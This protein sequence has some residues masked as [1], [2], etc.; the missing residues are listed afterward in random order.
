MRI[1][2]KLF[3]YFGILLLICFGVATL[4]T[5]TVVRM[6]LDKIVYANVAKMNQTIADSLDGS[7][8]SALTTDL[9][10][11]RDMTG[12]DV[13]VYEGDTL[14]YSSFSGTAPDLSLAS[15]VSEEYEV[16]VLHSGD[17]LD[18]Y[19]SEMVGDSPYRVFF[20][21]GEDAT[22]SDDRLFYVSFIGIAFLVFSV[23]AVSYFT[24]R[25]FT[26]PIRELAEYANRINPDGIPEP[27]PEFDTLEFNEL[28]QALEKASDRLQE[29]HRNEQE[30]LH[31]FSH[32]MKTPLTNI[33]GYAEAMHYDMLSP[34]ENKTA[35]Q[36]IMTESEK[37]R[38]TIDQILLLG[39]LD[40]VNV[41]FRFQKNNVVD[42]LNDALDRV[43]MPAKEA[44]IELRFPNAEED[45]YLLCDPDQ[46]EAAFVNVLTNGIRYARS[47]VIV[48]LQD[49]SE[50]LVVVFDDDGPGIPGDEAGKIFERFYTGYKGHT[51]LGLPITRSIVE[52]H[53][54]TVAV[55]TSPDNGAR[56]SL[57]FPRKTSEGDNLPERKKK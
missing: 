7:S 11:A 53:G 32:E 30:F 22:F 25:S 28:G 14:V 18:Y 4:L 40:S 21:R 9:E 39:R 31:N 45:H 19:T 48:T 44:G 13:M 15:R 27:G 42:I 43:A 16:Y 3:L 17:R 36:V 23:S 37:L 46:L 29:Y 2:H 20:F 12:V 38:T 10:I 8:L 33:Y 24:T 52:H 34:E 56:F 57:T 35:S 6:T 26:E 47:A 41:A 5:R 51:G 50:K 55:G 1:R 49:F 54:G